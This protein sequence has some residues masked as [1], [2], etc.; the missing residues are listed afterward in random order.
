MEQIYHNLLRIHDACRG[1]SDEEVERLGGEAEVLRAEV[2]DRVHSADHSVDSILIVVQGVLKVVLEKP[3]GR[4]QTLRFISAGDQFGAMMLLDDD[5]PPLDVFVEERAVLL[6]L[7]RESVLELAEEFPVFRR[8]LLRKVGCGVRELVL[9]RQGRRMPKIVAFVCSDDPTR[10]LVGEFA[11]R[12]S[13][14]R[15]ASGDP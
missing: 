9:P 11:C 7:K 13:R 3:G 6:R 4:K 2:G 15:R 1:L 10:E 12:L 14:N 8:N 5:E